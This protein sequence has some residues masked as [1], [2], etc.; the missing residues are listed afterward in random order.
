MNW[1]K[2]LFSRGRF[3]GDLSQEMSEH[4]EEKVA[5]LVAGGMR[6]EEARYEAQRQF[7]NTLLLRE[8]CRDVWVLQW[9]EALLQDLR[10]ALRQLR[11]NP[12]FTT[13]AVATLALG[14]GASTTIF[15][16]VDSILLRPLPYRDP[17]RL[18]LIRERIPK[19]LPEPVALPAPDVVT[20]RRESR[21]ISGL[22]AFQNGQLDLTGGTPERLMGAR[23]TASLFPLLGVRPLFGRLFA[24]DEDQPN[25]YVVLLSY[26]LWQRRFG[27]D[28]TILGKGVSI[29][30]KS[31]LVVGVMPAGFEFPFPGVNGSEPA[32]LW[33]PMGFS[34][35]ELKDFGDNFNYTVVARLKPS[36]TLAEANADISATAHGI[37]AKVYKGLS[38]FTLEAEASPLQAVIVQPARPLLLILMGGVTLVLLISCTNV[39]GLM[40]V[41]AAKRQKEM[42]IRAALGAGRF[43]VF[44]GLLVE[45]VLLGILAGVLG[46]LMACWG[47]SLLVSLAPITLLRTQPINL[48][49]HVLLFSILISLG[50][51]L[52]FGLLPAFGPSRIDLN[53]P[54]KEGGRTSGGAAHHR[55][56]S[57][58][59]IAEIA[60]SLVL[61]ASAGL[62]V[63]S[64]VRVRETDPGFA[65]QH[66]LTATVT[67]DRSVYSQASSV[68]SFYNL[69][70]QR[71]ASLPGVRAT[72]ASTDLPLEANWNHLFT[73]E[74]HPRQPSGR[75]PMGDHSA[76]AG[77]YLQTLGVSLIRGRY[78]THEDS[79]RSLRVV[80]V[81]EGLAKRYWPGEDPIGK[82]IKWGPPESHSPWLTVVG[83]V[84]DVKQGPLDLP[85][86][87]HTYQ[88][89]AQLNDSAVEAIAPSLHLAVRAAGEPASLTAAIRAQLRTLDPGVPLT[90][91]RT[92]G[93]I[94]ANSISS[95]RFTT[96]LLVAFAAAALLLAS[97]GLYGVIAYAVSQRTHE[98]GIRMA[99][100][101]QKSDVLRLVVGQGMVMVLA[102]VGIGIAGALILTRFLASLLY[103]VKPTDP[104]TFV[105][106]PV[107]LTSVALLAC[108]IP[109]RRAT[110][111]DPMMALRH[112]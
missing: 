90:S 58:L 99:L 100:G 20:F 34:P 16:A 80:I 44:R 57:V 28:R 23:I 41:R 74:E 15:S 8:E 39:A 111:V 26:G 91:V 85:I 45:S 9:F 4:L 59:V 27:A 72:G 84:G 98:F 1:I 102:G 81:S 86:D 22:G 112:E 75:S 10:Y 31:Y 65:P 105:V 54:L 3:H 104:L 61:L 68:R 87:P 108:F 48:N 93:A 70:L 6:P 42:A 89:L 62:L 109:A 66:L 40:F 2:Q 101:A 21:V 37:Q 63:R 82:R 46:L 17:Q 103:G 95:R 106:V 53:G 52:V 110:K 69:F 36:V 64:F 51:G 13:V 32:E 47:L 96:L 79:A 76:I 30:R 78:F 56:R 67:L 35:E 5:E 11:R 50:T 33:V 38:G 14:I 71:V 83:V 97:V 7:G 94:L 18:V 73:V 24:E 29:D 107:L 19:V 12:G 25:R 88:P 55:M 60:L 92:M 49:G 77:S 43:R